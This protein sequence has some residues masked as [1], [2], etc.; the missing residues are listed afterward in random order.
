M[1]HSATSAALGLDLGWS[2]AGGQSMGLSLSANHAR[3]NQS[4]TAASHVDSNLL[5]GERLSLLTG[6]DALIAGAQ[7]DSSKNLPILAVS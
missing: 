3:G 6:N 4:G 7:L 1:R 5:A 2:V